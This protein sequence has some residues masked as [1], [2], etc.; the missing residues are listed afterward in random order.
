MTNVATPGHRAG[1]GRGAGAG[2][3]GLLQQRNH[4]PH[5]DGRDFVTKRKKRE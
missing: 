1:W 4:E 3:C 5:K 2:R